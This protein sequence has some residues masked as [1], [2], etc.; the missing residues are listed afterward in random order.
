MLQSMFCT[1]DFSGDNKI[2]KDEYMAAMGEVPPQEHKYTRHYDNLCTC[3]TKLYYFLWGG[4]ATAIALWCHVATASHSGY[5]PPGHFPFHSTL[6]RFVLRSPP[7]WHRQAVPA[8]KPREDI[9]T[10]LKHGCKKTFQT[11]IKR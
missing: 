2:S 1:V 11:E 4:G 3:I 7:D 8:P 10:R 6:R 5:S 9:S